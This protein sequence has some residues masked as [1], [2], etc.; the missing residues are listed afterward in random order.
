MINYFETEWI[1]GKSWTILIDNVGMVELQFTNG[2]RYAYL[3][4]LIVSSE[5]QHKGLGTKLMSKAEE[6]VKDK[7]F[8]EIHLK[9][10]KEKDLLVKW[11]EKLGYKI[12]IE[13]DD[14]LYMRKIF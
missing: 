2:Y 11:Y 14:Y 13:E 3:C 8:N 1:W 6:I 5:H 12:I 7:G 10:E 9:V 4:N